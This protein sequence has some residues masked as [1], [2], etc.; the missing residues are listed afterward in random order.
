MATGLN[1]RG[2]G[3]LRYVRFD[4]R[5]RG[6]AAP[7]HSGRTF[8]IVAAGGLLVLAGSL[9]GLFRDWRSRYR[10]L[11]AYGAQV[12]AP[13]IDPLAEQT[14]PGIDPDDWRRAVADTHAVLVTV[15]ASG[16]LDHAK[17][18][19]LRTEIGER[20]A[21]ASPDTAIDE[22]GRVFL[23]M[24]SMWF[25]SYTFDDALDKLL[26]GAGRALEV[27]DTGHW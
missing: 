10:A 15:T 19:A 23:I 12:V 14:P 16:L 24:D 1:G 26:R 21:R 2:N 5:V 22:L 17:M 7:V 18:E 8:V 9:L 4:T 20:V 27:D 25:V 3:R 11:A 13:A 6:K